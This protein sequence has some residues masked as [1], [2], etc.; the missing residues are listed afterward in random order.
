MVGA[1]RTKTLEMQVPSLTLS[2][3]AATAESTAN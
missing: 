2:V 1:E 3:C